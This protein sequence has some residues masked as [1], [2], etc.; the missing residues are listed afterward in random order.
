MKL[1]VKFLM[2]V[3]VTAL[4]IGLLTVV[5][6]SNIKKI[7]KYKDYQSVQAEATAGVSDIFTFLMKMDYSDFRPTVGYRDFTDKI[8]SL[9]ADFNYLI[10]DE[11]T[12]DF[13]DELRENLDSIESIWSLL[14]GR[15]EPIEK[16]LEQ[17]QDIKLSNS[18]QT[19]IYASGIRIAHQDFPDEPE[20]TLLNNLLLSVHK[21]IEGV[22]RNYNTM[23]KLNMQSSFQFKE[24]LAGIEKRVVL[25]TIIIAILLSVFLVLVILIIT[26]N[27][28]RQIGSI[29]DMTSTLAKKDFSGELE[30]KG[31]S[32]I[33]SL[34]EN[35]NNMVNQINEF[36]TVVKTTA[37]KAISSGYSINDSANS[38]AA[39]TDEININIGKISDVFDKIGKAVGK[40][41]NAMVLMNE[42]VS[43]LLDNNKTQANAIDASNGAVNSAAETLDVINKMA[44]ERSKNAEEMR[45]LVADGD[46][47]ISLTAEKLN[48][49][50][51]QLDEIQDVVTIINT[52]ANQTNLLSMNAAIESAH[53]GEAGKGFSVVAEEIRKLAEETAKN[54]KKIKTVVNN[55]V[56]SV[57][58]ANKSSMEASDA[59][60][61]VSTHADEVIN[62][63]KE[64]S[65]GVT[66]VDSQMQQIKERTAETAVVAEKISGYC[67][68]LAEQH[69]TVSTEVGFMSDLFIETR[70]DLGRIRKGTSDI[71]N[72]MKD[73]RDASKESYKNM[74]DLENILE[75]F[76]TKSEVDAA[77]AKVDEQNAIENVVSIEMNPE[78]AV[79]EPTENKE[80]I[81]FDL[82]DV[83]EY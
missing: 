63:L 62:S 5:S 46:E 29:E 66:K 9:D 48:E 1:N 21:D 27:V 41:I 13:N 72:R 6:I 82:N 56:T 74:T 49:I 19:S 7:S 26:G 36:F 80:E 32:E 54:A 33:Y 71:V 8:S 60:V 11:I 42:H 37:S 18:M 2:I 57:T 73:V 35:I 65:D 31:S 10:H 61:K 58:N 24:V 34:M 25:V 47:K 23:T 53:A 79:I 81:T 64:I 76:K 20:V 16:V 69:K 70:R 28:V 59:F 43:T 17:M 55:I 78:F 68:D 40:S 67:G 15:F 52:V 77:V 39:A 30:A 44:F 45:V 50:A 12:K 4:G 38:T 51:G 22:Y 75:E 14:K 3:A 83:Q